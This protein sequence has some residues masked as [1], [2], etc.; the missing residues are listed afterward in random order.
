M[1]TL[2]SLHQVGNLFQFI[3][4]N[5]TAFLS[6]HSLP[7]RSVPVGQLGTTVVRTMPGEKSFIRLY[8]SLGRQELNSTRDASVVGLVNTLTSAAKMRVRS[9]AINWAARERGLKGGEVPELVTGVLSAYFLY[10][11]TQ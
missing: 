10:E 6:V 4:T 2:R 8:T 5:S 7:C 1:I 11:I 3:F 9:A